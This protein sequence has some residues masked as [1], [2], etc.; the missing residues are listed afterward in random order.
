[1]H[2]PFLAAT[3]EGKKDPSSLKS[4]H[5]FRREYMLN[6]LIGEWYS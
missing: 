5:F 4:T 1:M 2:F 6:H 3:E